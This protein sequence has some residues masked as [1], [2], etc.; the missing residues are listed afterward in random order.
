MTTGS[1]KAAIGG[2]VIL[3]ALAC[4]HGTSNVAAPTYRVAYFTWDL[5]L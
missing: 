5:S 4:G 2:L 3:A 1:A